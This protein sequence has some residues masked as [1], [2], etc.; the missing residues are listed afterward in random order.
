MSCTKELN[1]KNTLIIIE[2]NTKEISTNVGDF[3]C[4]KDT[5]AVLDKFI[6][7]FYLSNKVNFKNYFAK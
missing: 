3:K 4:D 1:F 5:L 6:A 7:V 2:E